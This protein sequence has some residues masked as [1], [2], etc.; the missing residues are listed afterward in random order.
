MSTTQL[1]WQRER[2]LA[3]FSDGVSNRGNLIFVTTQKGVRYAVDDIFDDVRNDELNLVM[4]SGEDGS[5]AVKLY[6][7]EK[8]GM[9]LKEDHDGLVSALDSASR[10]VS[11]RIGS[12][13]IVD[14][15]NIAVNDEARE[16]I[17]RLMGTTDVH[18]VL[19]VMVEDIESMQYYLSHDPY[20][21]IDIEEKSGAF[22]L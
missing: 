10:E 21:V 8:N 11:D 19:I 9:E 16:D 15:S 22:S 12:V 7:L 20:I 14:A 2:P 5:G 6:S 17:N 3:D 18:V 13:V 1:F 4:I